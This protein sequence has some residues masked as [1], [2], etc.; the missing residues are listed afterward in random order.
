[1]RLVRKQARFIV[2]TLC[3]VMRALDADPDNVGICFAKHLEDF[4]IL[5]LTSGSINPLNLAAFLKHQRTFFA[6]L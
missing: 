3:P 1:M 6:R 5:S 4:R 2:S